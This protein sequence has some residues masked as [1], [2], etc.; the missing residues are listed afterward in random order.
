[1]FEKEIKFISDFSLNKVKKFGSFITFEKL[2]GTDLHPAIITYISS[3]FDYMIYRDR[4]KLLADSIFDYS[5][6]QIIDQF[7]IIAE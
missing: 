3:E 4:K 7:K 1:M 6:R 2:S 5:G